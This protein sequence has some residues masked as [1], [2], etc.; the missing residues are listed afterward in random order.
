MLEML[1]W[2]NKMVMM[3]ISGNDLL[4]VLL[5][6]RKG[7]QIGN[8]GYLQ[9]STTILYYDDDDVYL[10]DLY[11]NINNNNT[12]ENNTKIDPAKS[13][14]IIVTDWLES[15]GDGYSIL[16]PKSSSSS[17]ASVVSRSAESL[18]EMVTMYLQKVSSHQTNFPLWN[19]TSLSTLLSSKSLSL[20]STS[21]SS[22]SSPATSITT[23]IWLHSIFHGL[24]GVLAEI[25]SLLIIYPLVTLVS[26]LQTS[27]SASG[28]INIGH[29]LSAF[30]FC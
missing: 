9:S 28:S 26:R 16:N 22:S 21:A 10:N 4:N 1:P 17:S 27:T 30:N 13:Y 2:E 7:G 20:A 24:I 23:P 25:V 18:R 19:S 15:G 29:F 6:S 8:G 12:Y 3:S 11:Y 5:H 14:Y